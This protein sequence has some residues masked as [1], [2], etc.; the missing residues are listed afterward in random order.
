MDDDL[1]N[2]NLNLPKELQDFLADQVARGQCGSPSE[3]VLGLIERERSARFRE[4]FEQE[5]VDLMAHG[6][7]IL[8]TPE[9]CRGMHEELE[10]HIA[11]RAPRRTP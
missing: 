8:A 11:A 3:F 7:F 2:M 9:F 4:L 5:L 6:D 1:V 10:S